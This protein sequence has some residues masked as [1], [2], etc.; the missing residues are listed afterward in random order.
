MYGHVSVRE[1]TCWKLNESDYNS[2]TS[3]TCGYT[4]RIYDDDQLLVRLSSL[5]VSLFE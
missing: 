5:S 3:Q 2:M 4:Y 1:R